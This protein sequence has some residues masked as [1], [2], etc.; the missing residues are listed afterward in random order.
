MERA[1]KKKLRHGRFSDV[2]PAHRRLM[3]GVRGS[4][5]RTTEARLRAALAR[6]GMSGWKLNVRGLP[7]SPDFY[8]PKQA[9]AIFVDGCFWHGCPSCG[10]VPKK[11]SAFWREKIIRNQDRDR[12][13]AAQLRRRGAC[14]L[15]FWEHE[16]RESLGGC[17]TRIQRVLRRRASRL[18]GSQARLV[19]LS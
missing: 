17:I 15:R 12:R 16:L 3:Q 13:Y 18:R 7:G 1:L 6:A 5:N 14:V 4:G 9:T 11:N 10:H 19:S 8:F 2:R